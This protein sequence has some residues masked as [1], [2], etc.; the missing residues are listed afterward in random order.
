MCVCVC[1]L[2]CVLPVC[3][4]LNS[5]AGLRPSTL[6]LCRGFP[7]SLSAVTSDLKTHRRLNFYSFDTK[8]DSAAVILSQTDLM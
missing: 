5:P 7:R 2:V 1:S 8:K 4:C 6:A 3:V